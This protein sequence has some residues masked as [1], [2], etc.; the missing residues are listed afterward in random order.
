MYQSVLIIP[1]RR[2]S[3][4]LRQSRNDIELPSP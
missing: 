1:F 4:R 3:C 2:C